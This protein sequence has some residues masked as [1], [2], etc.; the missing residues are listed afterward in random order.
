MGDEI[1]TKEVG[2][3]CIMYGGEESGLVGKPERKG[4]LERPW[5]RWEDTIQIDIR[6]IGEGHRL[7]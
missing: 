7:D 3:A 4:I 6:E 2:G 1:K 5:H